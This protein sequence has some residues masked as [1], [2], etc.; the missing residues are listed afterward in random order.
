VTFEPGESP[1]H[2]KGASYLGYL[3]YLSN[4]LPGGVPAFLAALPTDK[5]R[6][7]IGQRF[8]VGGWYDAL[9]WPVLARAAARLS[10]ES[11]IDHIDRASRDQFRRDVGGLYRAI[12]RVVGPRI[13]CDRLVRVTNQYFD[14]GPI[15]A[16]SIENGR[17]ILVRSGMPQGLCEWY[18]RV[19]ASYGHAALRAAGARAVRARRRGARAAAPAGHL[20]ARLE[21]R[22]GARK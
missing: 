15:H 11:L 16:R 13:A 21:V 4:T 8:L 5:Y 22:D 17:A 1:F 6:A 7:F 18:G 3:T 20:P 9:P 14:F 2:V 10:G 12:L 19:G